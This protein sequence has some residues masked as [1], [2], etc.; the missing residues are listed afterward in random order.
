MIPTTTEA[1]WI[2]DV[3]AFDPFSGDQGDPGDRELRDKIVKCKKGGHCHGCTEVFHA[4]DTIRRIVKVY[5]ADGLMAF[6]FC[7]RCCDA[8][9]LSWTDGGTALQARNLA[10]GDD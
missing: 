9:A 7:K 3:L 4:G 10:R 8:Q 6:A 2:K 1:K 5:V